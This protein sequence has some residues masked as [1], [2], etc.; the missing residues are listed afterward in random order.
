M[1]RQCSRVGL[2]LT[3]GEA[4][5][6]EIPTREEG[7]GLVKE[8]PTTQMLRALLLN[9]PIAV[10]VLAPF[11]LHLILTALALPGY[12]CPFNAVTGLPCCGCGISRAIVLLMRG[13]FSAMAAT[14]PFAPYFF[15]LGVLTGV[16]VL[17]SNSQRGSLASVVVWIERRT[18]MNAIALTAFA[19]YGV[20]I[21]VVRAL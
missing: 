14:H 21:L 2:N 13:D 6:H 5:G 15:A 11:C 19:V 9:R 20:V 1:P 8:P 16:S 7:L 4:F 10:A 18:W 17:L 3:V 12:R